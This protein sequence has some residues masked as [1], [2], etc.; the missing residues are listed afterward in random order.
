M[1]FFKRIFAGKMWDRERVAGEQTILPKKG[2]AA[3]LRCLSVDDPRRQ[4]AEALDRWAKG[5]WKQRSTAGPLAILPTRVAYADNAWRDSVSNC[6]AALYPRQDFTDL[7]DFELFVRYVSS[8]QQD[9]IM[10]GQADLDNFYPEPV[11]EG[12][13]AYL[14]SFSKTKRLHGLKEIVA[15]VWRWDLPPQFAWMRTLSYDHGFDKG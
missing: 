5:R 4:S 13:A 15:E 9:Q 2:L 3:A 7:L 12:V 11:K 1:Q 10:D 14:R 6:Y 8:I